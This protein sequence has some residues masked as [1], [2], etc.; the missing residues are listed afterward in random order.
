MKIKTD[1]L[2][3]MFIIFN[4]LTSQAVVAQELLA[5][6]HLDE[7]VYH[8]AWSPDSQ[9][10]AVAS[11]SGVRIYTPDL[12]QIALL[13]GHAS[14]NKVGRVAWSP[15][16]SQLMS[17]GFGDPE[18][19]LWKRDLSTNGFN[20]ENSLPSYI[21]AYTYVRTAA[22]SPDGDKFALIRMYQP[23]GFLGLLGITELLDTHSW[24]VKDRFPDEFAF[25][26]K[27]LVWSPDGS[28][29]ASA[30][31]TCDTLDSIPACDLPSFYVVD[32]STGSVLWVHED[33]EVTYDLAWSPDGSKLAIGGS[34][35]F[36]F[37]PISGERIQGW[38]IDGP[39]AG[40]P[41]YFDWS[42]D[43]RQLAAATQKGLVTVFDIET[44]DTVLSFETLTFPEAV[45]ALDW[46]STGDKLAIGA[47]LADEYTLAP[48]GEGVV[49]VWS[50]GNLP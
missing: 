7:L 31:Y 35:V 38:D 18:L 17:L 29:I 24:Q 13:Q 23:E 12:Q 48:G 9:V 11:D 39:N 44:G 43:G 3:G 21:S 28:K 19:R 34:E 26:S 30:F 42:P 45:H 25:P 50:I 33:L 15:D 32:V 20:L 2:L 36:I 8:V 46:N 16:G 37:D 40:M 1:L 6:I 49:E 5:Q 10:L 41:E 4:S 27:D 22:W 47:A 14:E